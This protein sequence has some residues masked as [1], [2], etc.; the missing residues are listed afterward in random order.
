MGS[1]VCRSP[2]S[3]NAAYPADPDRA[4]VTVKALCDKLGHI[5]PAVSADLVR[6]TARALGPLPRA[7]GVSCRP[8]SPGVA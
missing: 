6:H 8:P 2:R 5:G 3:I 4:G 1:A 7:T